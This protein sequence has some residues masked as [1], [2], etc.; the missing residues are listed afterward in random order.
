MSQLYSKL[1]GNNQ[2]SADELFQWA[3]LPIIISCGARHHPD[4]MRN[5]RDH[6]KVRKYECEY[7][8][9]MQYHRRAI[10]SVALPYRHRRT[11]A[12]HT[13]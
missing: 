13:V 12:Y 9:S 2:P 1:I 5:F 3:L 4:M 8:V 10:S 7:N 6:R 11:F